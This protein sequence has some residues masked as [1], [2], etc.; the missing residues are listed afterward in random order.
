VSEKNPFEL[1]ERSFEAEYFEKKNNSLVEKLRSVFH[2]DI[3]KESIRKETGITDEALLDRLVHV[4]L[5]GELMVAFKLIPIIEVAWADGPPDAKEQRAV[6][7]SGE[8]SGI[9]RGSRA[10]EMLERRLAEGPTDDLRKIW[11]LYANSLR[12]TLNPTELAEFR[13][14]LLALCRQIAETSGGILGILMK[15]SPM[16]KRVID[17]VEKALS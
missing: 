4:N 2:K 7:E 5:S 8:R 1:R 13:A 15:T 3:N 17:A 6:L 16:E 11:R 12:E 10:F 14:D 9:P